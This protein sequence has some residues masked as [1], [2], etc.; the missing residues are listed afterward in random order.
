LPLNSVISL[1]NVL[2]VP[3]FKVNL[4]SIS[5]VTR[6]LNCSVTFFPYWCILQD[7]ATKTTIGLGK[8][9]GRF[10]YLVALASPTPT[11]NFQSSAP[12][13]TKSFFSHVISSTE[14]WH[15]RLG[16]LS[17]SRLNFMA[18][19][20]LNFSF[21]L[22]DACDICA[23]SKQ[24][25]LPFSSSS[26]SSIRP[27]ELIHC[28]IWGPYKIP[29]LSGAK[30]FLTIVD[31]YSRFTWVFFMHHKHETQNLLNFFFPL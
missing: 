13:A 17:F 23:L 21:K 20:L 7:L 30:Y 12:I 3:S 22:H 26:I 1:K 29:S 10:Y 25:R 6:G 14:L 4:M 27:F 5:R 16:H 11:P 15:R 24:C 19:N 18:N 28:D 2:G 31:D 9:R 8:Q